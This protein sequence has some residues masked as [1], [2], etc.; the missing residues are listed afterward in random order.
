[1]T[2]SLWL[3]KLA[4]ICGSAYCAEFLKKKKKDSYYS[5]LNVCVVFF[6][7][8]F[9]NFYFVSFFLFIFAGIFR[10]FSY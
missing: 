3:V 10:F 9:L 8:S 1:M 2:N 7:N 6:A 5:L 4:R